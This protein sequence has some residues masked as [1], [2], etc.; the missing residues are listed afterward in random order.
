MK[1]RSTDFW[2]LVS[3]AAFPTAILIAYA[4]AIA[5]KEMG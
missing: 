5:F 4:I 1:P 3:V 2:I